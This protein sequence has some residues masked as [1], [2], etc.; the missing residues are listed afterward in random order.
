MNLYGHVDLRLVDRR[1]INDVLPLSSFITGF[2]LKQ[3]EDK[4]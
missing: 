2:F 3:Q 4:K 1:V